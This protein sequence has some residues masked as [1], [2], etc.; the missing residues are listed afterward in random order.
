MIC[1]FLAQYK[2]YNRKEGGDTCIIVAQYEKYNKKDGGDTCIIVMI[3][4]NFIILMM[5]NCI[6][7]IWEAIS[8]S[9]T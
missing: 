6:R 7:G 4:R 1:L 3:I 9:L 2:K 5:Y 8:G